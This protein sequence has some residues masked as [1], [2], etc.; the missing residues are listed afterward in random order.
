MNENYIGMAVHP[1]IK[2]AAAE[3]DYE[4]AR[5]EYCKTIIQQKPGTAA[6]RNAQLL[7]DDIK[8]QFGIV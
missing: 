1:W 2:E 7:I 8:E 6:A 5:V 3:Y 4:K